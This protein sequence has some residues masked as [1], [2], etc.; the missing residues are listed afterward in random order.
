ML[1]KAIS[2]HFALDGI[3]NIQREYGNITHI[4]EIFQI[5]KFAKKN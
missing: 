3:E 2:Q 1:R 4:T 5:E